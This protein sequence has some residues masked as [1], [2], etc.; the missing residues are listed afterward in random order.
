MIQYF[1]H[2]FSFECG[3]V[4][5]T[6]LRNGCF[7]LLVQKEAKKTPGADSGEHKP[8]AVLTVI[9]P[10]DPQLRGT[11]SYEVNL[12]FRREKFSSVI[13][14]APGLRPYVCKV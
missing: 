10:P 12:T 13:L 1:F 9:L 3:K 5:A 11:P 7:F 4:F 6:L 8:A 14:L 2:I